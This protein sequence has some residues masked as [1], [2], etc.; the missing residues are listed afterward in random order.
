MY[1]SQRGPVAFLLVLPGHWEKGNQRFEDP[2][3]RKAIVSPPNYNSSSIV[4]TLPPKAWL[5]KAGCTW[6]LESGRSSSRQARPRAGHRAQSGRKE[7]FPSKVLHVLGEYLVERI[8]IV[9][10]IYELLR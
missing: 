5:S 8:F 4:L 6:G 2:V 10:I 7:G 3:E 9:K 1:L